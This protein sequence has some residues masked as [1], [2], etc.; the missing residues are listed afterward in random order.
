M[1][2]TASG[3]AKAAIGSAIT[4]YTLA[5]VSPDA[6]LTSLRVHTQYFKWSRGVGLKLTELEAQQILQ[7]MEDLYV[8][9][10]YT[11][12]SDFATREHFER[13]IRGLDMTSSPGYPYCLEK[14]TIGE[15]LGWDGLRMDAMKVD[16]LYYDC[17]AFIGGSLDSFYRVF[18]KS[19]PHTKAKAEVGRWRLIVCP[20]LY[21]Q[22]T[23]TVWFG[24]GNDKEIETTGQ[25]PSMQGM[26]LCQ[27]DWKDHNRLF[28]QKGYDTPMDK[29]AWD[30]TAHIEWIML[31]LEL[32]DRLMTAETDVK[33]WWRQVASRLYE[34]AF[35]HPR[36]LLSN[37][38]VWEQQYP[39]IMKSGCVNT[40]STNSHCQLFVH[41]H[42]C[43]RVGRSPFPA[44]VAVGDDTLG[45]FNNQVTPCEYSLSAVLVKPMKKGEV[46][47][48]GH[49]FDPAFGA[50]PVPAYNAKHV[51]RYLEIAEQ[52]LKEFLESM[53]YLYAHER[54]MQNLWRNV[55][56]W[57]GILLPSEGYVRTWYDL[58]PY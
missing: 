47:F 6:E 18:V 25:T 8:K 29:T 48:V 15:W 55:A 4:D 58:R 43:L 35:N 40:I 12:A 42:A 30:W 23:W 33:R 22:V 49:D 36:L 11:L 38:S 10:K 7:V 17:Q 24:Q 39:G 28:R 14:P 3:R 1:A 26:K 53:V 56:A 27:G 13:V 19:E 44:P 46:Q 45:T 32:R 34:R 9:A 41:V 57:H 50:P 20:P 54:D 31:D 16:R 37:G 52:N 5:D 51:F 2:Q 21:E